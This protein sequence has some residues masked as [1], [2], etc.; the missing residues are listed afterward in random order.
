[1][2]LRFVSKYFANGAGFKL[3]YDFTDVSHW[4]YNFGSCG[5]NFTTPNGFLTSPS[6]PNSYP[7]YADCI[8]TISQPT[9][10][11]IL[12][13]FLSIA[14]EYRGNDCDSDYLDIR[15]GL[16]SDAPLLDRLC[17]SEI[18]DLIQTSQNHLWMK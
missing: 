18:P 12:L 17:G 15:E 5:G 14:I 1:M 7:N 2:L 9:G 8:Y 3:R 13:K 6:Y 10:T 4:S 11:V 16:T